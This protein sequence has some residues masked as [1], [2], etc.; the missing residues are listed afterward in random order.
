MIIGYDHGMGVT[1]D[2]GEN[3][4]HPDFQ[5]LA[6]FYA[7]GIDMSRPYRVAGGLQDNGSHMA[8]H[9]NPAGGPVYFEMWERVGGGDGMYNE[10]GCENRYLYN[11]S[12]FGP[13]ARTDL[14]TGERTGIRYS[15]DDE[16]R[17]NWN[18][19]ILVSPH[20]CRTIFHGSNKL[21]KSENQG[22]SW[23]VISPDLTK[24][25]PATLTT[26][27]GGDGNIEYATLTTVD[28]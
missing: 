3:W 14:W 2:G 19:P 13:I 1:Y 10:F 18:A 5:S 11:E 27:K 26:G 22:E 8:P 12:Q 20:D 21:L 9:T 4:Y 17:F 15:E 23:E 7:V 16:L 28:Q 6:Q 24:A 25:D